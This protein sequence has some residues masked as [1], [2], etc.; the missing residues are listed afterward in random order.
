MSW[1]LLVSVRICWLVSF[2]TI[3]TNVMAP[4]WILFAGEL[5]SPVL[6]L[7]GGSLNFPWALRLFWP[8]SI[9]LIVH[10][11]VQAFSSLSV[12]RCARMCVSLHAFLRRVL[13]QVELSRR[14]WLSALS[15]SVLVF[16]CGDP[17]WT[18]DYLSAS[19]A[20]SFSNSLSTTG[21]VTWPTPGRRFSLPSFVCCF[22]LFYVIKLARFRLK[23]FRQHRGGA[24]VYV[25]T[26]WCRNGV[27]LWLLLRRRM[28]IVQ[29]HVRRGVKEYVRKV[30][31]ASQRS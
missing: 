19:K 11:I 13:R 6:I 5:L 25:L 14:H 29:Q 28:D 4:P 16:L 3:W 10:L 17:L 20:G 9:V 7:S 2:V 22:L 12:S 27:V 21:Q 23:L 24:I 31:I 1:F 26:Y 30:D 8:R 15:L 18:G